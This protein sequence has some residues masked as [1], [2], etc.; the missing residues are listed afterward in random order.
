MN[1]ITNRPTT[2]PPTKYRMG[3]ATMEI[4]IIRRSTLMRPR[5][6]DIQ[7]DRIRP[8][9]L[10]AAPT[11]RPKAAR[12]VLGIPTLLAKGT[13][14]LMTI[15]PAAVPHAYAIHMKY[16]VGV[17]SASPGVKSYAVAAALA[18]GFGVQPGTLYPAGGFFSRKAPIIV[19]TKKITPRT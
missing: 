12:V 5:W 17:R 13:S 14:W 10:P 2:L 18:A 8:L 3:M 16:I 15:R 11:T 4:P 7:P 9:A 1:S 19:I 6:S